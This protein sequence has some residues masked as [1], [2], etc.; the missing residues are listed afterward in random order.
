VKGERS[1]PEYPNRVLPEAVTDRPVPPAGTYT[2]RV[3]FTAPE[4]PGHYRV[5]W[6][7]YDRAGSRVRISHTMTIWADFDVRGV[8]G[9][10]KVR[11][12]PPGGA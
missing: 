2:F 3:P 7:M 4:R 10:K 9:R 12:T 11:L 8:S 1:K 5:H 6:G